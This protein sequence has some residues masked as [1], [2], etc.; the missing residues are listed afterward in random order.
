MIIFLYFALSVLIDAYEPLVPKEQKTA[1]VSIF[2]ECRALC[3]LLSFTK[4]SRI[5]IA[6]CFSKL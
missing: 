3:L 6:S 5:N 2:D 1:P 4:L